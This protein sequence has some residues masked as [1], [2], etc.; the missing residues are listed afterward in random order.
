MLTKIQR[1]NYVKKAEEI[2]KMDLN[3]IENEEPYKEISKRFT[4]AINNYFRAIAKENGWSLITKGHSFC[5][6]SCFFTNGNKFIY[7]SISDFRFW[8]WKGD[9]LYRQARHEQDYTGFHNQYCT[10]E[11]IED[12]LIEEFNR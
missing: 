7:V 9:V 11:E 10:L 4:K 2:T 3:T 1:Q 6:Y 5:G 8:D 12:S